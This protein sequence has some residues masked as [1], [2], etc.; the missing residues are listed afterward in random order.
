MEIMGSLIGLVIVGGIIGWLINQRLKGENFPGK[1]YPHNVLVIDFENLIAQFWK[2]KIGFSSFEE[3]KLFEKRLWE[4]KKRF[5]KDSQ[6]IK[7]MEKQIDMVAEIVANTIWEIVK[8]IRKAGNGS[9]VNLIYLVGKKNGNI[10]ML[11][12]VVEKLRGK[13]FKGKKCLVVGKLSPVE[14]EIED[15]I[16]QSIVNHF[17]YNQKKAL[18]KRDEFKGILQSPKLAKMWEKL[19]EWNREGELGVILVSKDKDFKHLKLQKRTTVV[20]NL[21]IS[22]KKGRIKLEFNLNRFRFKREVKL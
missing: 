3:Y 7:E 4:L 8:S 16:I 6:V 19:F 1:I 9:E 14:T 20:D 15:D 12:K 11:Y 18:E 22:N 13:C 2:E 10:A 21:H 17:V 5:R